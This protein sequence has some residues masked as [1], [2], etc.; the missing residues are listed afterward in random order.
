[1]V[2]ASSSEPLSYRFLDGVGPV[3][4]LLA[5]CAVAGIG[6]GAVS[7]AFGGWFDA[8]PVLSGVVVVVVCALFALIFGT[9]ASLVRR[10]REVREAL[11]GGGKN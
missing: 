2:D 4:K 7:I 5:L 8:V 10:S 1:M 3:L 9:L 6:F 11:E